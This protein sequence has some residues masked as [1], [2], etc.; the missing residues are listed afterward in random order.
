M[1]KAFLVGP[2]VNHF[3]EF[4]I[5]ALLNRAAELVLNYSL[6]SFE[7]EKLLRLALQELRCLLER[8][9]VDLRAVRHGAAGAFPRIKDGESS[10]QLA[11]AELGDLAREEKLR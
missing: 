3:V 10:Q 5:Q 4:E 7:L 1:R 2:I 9:R 8:R 6:L 11:V